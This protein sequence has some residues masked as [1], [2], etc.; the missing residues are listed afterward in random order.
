MSNFTITGKY[1]GAGAIR[2]VGTNK[3]KIRAFWIDITQ[4][5]HPNTPE[6]T[7]MGDKVALVENIEKGK[8][9][10][11]SFNIKGNKYTNLE[12][13]TSIITNLQAWRISVIKRESAATANIV[14]DPNQ[15]DDL[16]F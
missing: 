3:T 9:I 10:E 12:N 14:P 5:Q 7:L 16:P 15:N 1:L 8:D 13:K 4:G 2:E 6:F 11:V